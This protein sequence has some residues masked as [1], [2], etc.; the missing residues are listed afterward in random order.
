[1]IGYGDMFI[2]NATKSTQGTHTAKL[3]KAKKEAW[4]TK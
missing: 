2:Q 4:F 3:W 1:M